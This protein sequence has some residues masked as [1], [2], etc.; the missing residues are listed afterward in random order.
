MGSLYYKHSIIYPPKPDSNCQG[1]YTISCDPAC[2]PDGGLVSNEN[3]SQASAAHV[4]PER[5]DEEE[6]HK[7]NSSKYNK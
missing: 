4:G 7:N 3:V 1:L 6:R 2:S 5:E